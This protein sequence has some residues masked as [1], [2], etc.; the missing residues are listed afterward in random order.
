MPPSTSRRV[1]A[2]SMAKAVSSATE[3]D[4]FTGCSLTW[5]SSEW[6]LDW[7]S[8]YSPAAWKSRAP[9]LKVAR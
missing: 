5:T 4:P 6:S 9:S 1:P 3:D 2:T 8:V 7:T